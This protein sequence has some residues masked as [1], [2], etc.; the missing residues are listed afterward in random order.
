MFKRKNPSMKMLNELQDFWHE[1]ADSIV[2]ELESIF[3]KGNVA[4]QKILCFICISPYMLFDDANSTISFPMRPPAPKTPIFSI[5][6]PFIYD[7]QYTLWLQ[8]QP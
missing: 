4:C 8:A 3:G 2:K 7:A 1:N 5:N 6:A